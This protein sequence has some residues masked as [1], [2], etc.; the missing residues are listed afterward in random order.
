MGDDDTRFRTGFMAYRRKQNGK[1]FARPDLLREMLQRDR[2]SGGL[3]LPSPML[4]DLNPNLVKLW[5]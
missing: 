3:F 1:R 2:L 5:N 4:E